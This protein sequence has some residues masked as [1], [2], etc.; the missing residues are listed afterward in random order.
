MEQGEIRHVDRFLENES[1]FIPRRMNW[2]NVPGTIKEA[3]STLDGGLRHTR[4]Q[5]EEL[6]STLDQQEQRLI[7]L[8]SRCSSLAS[9]LEQERHKT[10]LL[11]HD[12][13]VSTR[14]RHTPDMGVDEVQI[15]RHAIDEFKRILRPDD[16]KSALKRL[17][18]DSRYPQLDRRIQALEQSSIDSSSRSRAL[19]HIKRTQAQRLGDCIAQLR[20]LS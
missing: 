8:E 20:K 5:V 4:S 11:T 2:L 17:S 1:E 18:T 6:A 16:V 7:A 19:E 13:Y 12:L 14:E 15:V 10:E 3:F 9:Q